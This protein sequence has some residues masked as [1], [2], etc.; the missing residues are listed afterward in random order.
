MQSRKKELLSCGSA[1]NEPDIKEAVPIQKSRIFPA[2]QPGKWAKTREFYNNKFYQENGTNTRTAVDMFHEMGEVSRGRNV[3]DGC[4]GSLG[5]TS[6]T[7][8]TV[9]ERKRNMKNVQI[10]YELFVA[11][12]EFRYGDCASINGS[13]SPEYG[14]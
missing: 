12:V 4:D 10:L 7:V 11:L 6:V 5:G 8:A 13:I 1:A 3:R 14:I 2:L 9:A